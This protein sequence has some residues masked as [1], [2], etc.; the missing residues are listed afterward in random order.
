M[1]TL[2]LLGPQ[3]HR[4][5]LA[6]VLASLNLTG[7]LAVIT[8]GWQEREAE[9]GELEGHLGL[10]IRNLSLH[11]RGEAIFE[12]APRFREAHRA[13]QEKLKRLQELYRMRLNN[14]MAALQQLMERSTVVDEEVLAPEVEAAMQDLRRLDAH[15]LNRLQEL[16]ADFEDRCPPDARKLVMDHHYETAEIVENSQSV[17]IAGGHVAVLLNRLRLLKLAPVLRERPLIAW[18]GGAMVLGKRLVLFH[19]TPPQGKGNAEI[20]ESGLNLVEKIVP[21][22]QASKRLHLADRQRV[23]RFARRFAPAHCVTLDEGAR[24]IYQ[25]GRW[26]ADGVQKLEN[27]GG[28]TAWEGT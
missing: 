7:P 25:D 10:P 26:R 11:A 27:D 2:V 9:T 8:A 23:S 14:H 12:Q 1:T 21:L 3:R 15:H 5:D 16:N 4:P 24:A 20:L 19:D 28:L 17:I 22:P 6:P 18:S 13:H